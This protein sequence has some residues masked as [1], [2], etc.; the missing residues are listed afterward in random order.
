MGCLRVI[1][2]N[3]S[4]SETTT[5]NSQLV[6]NRLLQLAHPLHQQD[7]TSLFQVGLLV[8]VTLH[9]PTPF[10]VSNPSSTSNR[11]LH[12]KFVT[13]SEQRCPHQQQPD[14]QQFVQGH[15]HQQQP[16]YYAPPPIPDV[17]SSGAEKPPALDLT[18][19]DNRSS[20]RLVIQIKGSLA[21]FQGDP[22]RARWELTNEDIL[23]RKITAAV[24]AKRHGSLQKTVVL[25]ARVLFTSSSAPK[26]LVAQC[27]AFRGN[28]YTDGG[29]RGFMYV[30]RGDH[31]WTGEDG[32]GIRVMRPNVMVRSTLM[33]TYGHLD[34]ESLRAPLT[35][36]KGT[37]FHMVPRNHEIMRIIELNSQKLGLDMSQYQSVCGDQ[38]PVV[39][40]L[41]ENCIGQIKR[42]VL[43]MKPWSDMSKGKL[44]VSLV[45]ADARAGTNS[46]GCTKCCPGIGSG[47]VP[48][49]V[50]NRVV[51]TPFVV[52]IWLSL[53]YAI[54]DRV[55]VG[56][57]ANAQGEGA[58]PKGVN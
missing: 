44:V 57:D 35:K 47:F 9:H 14:G 22:R 27:S 42:Q 50:V 24:G 21:S 48:D 10:P 29:V 20:R 58:T 12:N 45:P 33:S 53:T 25:D 18:H 5:L 54:A 40:P 37:T 17:A 34:E 43:N 30:P 11:A 51:N 13:T 2:T 31:Q 15:Y 3:S 26:S 52:E 32:R 1:H 6:D 38:F 39:D 4:K 16:Q 41:V 19:K 36:V 23:K 8:V 55:F 46:W 49:R 28:T 56:K 7:F